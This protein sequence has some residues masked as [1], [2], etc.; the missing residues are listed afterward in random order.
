MDT[1]FDLGGQQGDGFQEVFVGQ[2]ADVHLQEVSLRSSFLINDR[3][4]HRSCNS[5]FLVLRYLGLLEAL[6]STT[7]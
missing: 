7:E 5:R 2:A 4:R 6:K 1:G 3:Q